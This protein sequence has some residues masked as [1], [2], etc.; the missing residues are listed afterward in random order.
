MSKVILFSLLLVLGLIGSQLPIS[1]G[2]LWIQLGTLFGL[3]FIMIHVGYEFEIDKSS[4]KQYGLDSLIAGANAAVPWILCS[5]YFAWALKINSWQDALLIARFSSPTSA[6]VLFS[7][8][9][10]AGLSGTWMFQK[11]RILAIFGDLEM[12]LLMIPL[13]IMIVGIKWEL[14]VHL[15]IIIAMLWLA[16]RYLRVWKLPTTYPWVMLY[17]GLITGVCELIFL[18]STLFDNVFPVH[19]EVLLPAFA[20]GCMLARPAG[21]DPHSDDAREGHQEGPAEKNEQRASTIVA[22]V[23]MC[24]V[25]LSMPQIHLEAINWS[26][27]TIHVLLITFLSNIGKM[28]PILCYRKE[29]SLRKRL[30]LCIGMF[31]RGEVGAGVLVVSMSYNIGGTALTVAILSLV[32]NLIMTGFFIVWVKKLLTRGCNQSA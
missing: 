4:P 15:L 30:A 7:M 29:A 11:A 9:A 2:E 26:T 13:K 6:G 10:A 25:G 27:L 19:L 31:P 12:L 16:W 32:L 14:A 23:F 24:L 1:T 21:Q 18:T 28:F 5:A 8:L 22:S 20:L 3:S 17:A